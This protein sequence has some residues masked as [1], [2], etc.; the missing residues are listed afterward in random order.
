MPPNAVEYFISKANHIEFMKALLDTPETLLEEQIAEAREIGWDSPSVYRWITESHVTRNCQGILILGAQLFVAS[1]LAGEDEQADHFRLV[2]DA[3]GIPV[4]TAY[5]AIAI[6]KCFGKTLF[7]ESHL[8]KYF[9]KESMKILSQV[10]TSPQ[11]PEAALELARDGNRISIQEAK[12]LR[13]AYKLTDTAEPRQKSPPKP[14]RCLFTGQMVRVVLG[15]K[16]TIEQAD[17]VEV[18]EELHQAIETI[19]THRQSRTTRLA[20]EVSHVG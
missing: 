13:A 11:A 3:I 2:C 17:W 6:W 15:P 20:E 14:S 19:Q 16:L 8:Q 5:S 12:R 7:V 18:V 10:N 4:K 1:K 9:P